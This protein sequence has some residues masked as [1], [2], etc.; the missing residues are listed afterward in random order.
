MRRA[1]Q[2]DGGDVGSAPRLSSSRTSYS[3][4]PLAPLVK[5]TFPLLPASH[6]MQ[7]VSSGAGRVAR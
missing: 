1:S 2:P 6:A 4:T 5:T 7:R 3:V